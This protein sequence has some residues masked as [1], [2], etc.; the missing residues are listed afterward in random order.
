MKSISVS[1]LEAVLEE[2]EEYLEELRRAGK[3]LN[4]QIDNL[5]EEIDE[6]LLRIY[7]SYRNGE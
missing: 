1:L 7:E 4:V 3:N 6:L 5:Q 2:R